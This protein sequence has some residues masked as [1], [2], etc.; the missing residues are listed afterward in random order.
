MSELRFASLYQVLSLL[1]V[2]VQ[3]FAIPFFIGVPE[4]GKAMLF[5]SIVFFAQSLLEPLFQSI[6]NKTD[7]GFY[8]LFDALKISFPF[9]VFVLASLLFLPF[10]F[11]IYDIYFI[12]LYAFFYLYITSICSFLFSTKAYRFLAFI[13]FSNLIVFVLSVLFTYSEMGYFSVIFSGFLSFLISSVLATTYL[14]KV[15]IFRFS[16]SHESTNSFRFLV[17]ASLFR[18]PSSFISSGFLIVL[19]FFSL[20]YS[21]IG[22]LRLVLST[23]NAGRYVNL[24]PVAV[25]QKKISDYYY[26]GFS[27]FSGKEFLYY[28]TS[29]VIYSFLAPVI[30]FIYMYLVGS[31]PYA[32]YFIVFVCSFY[33]LLQPI[34]YA[35]FCKVDSTSKAPYF[36]YLFLTV[37]LC[38]FS[39]T[40]TYFEIPPYIVLVFIIYISLFYVLML[41]LKGAKV[42]TNPPRHG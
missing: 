7:V 19:G 12:F 22:D 2:L 35:F 17:G 1:F 6:F 13:S 42:E 34:S 27:I 3:S 40:S 10:D 16:Y 25:I 38:I 31:E 26:R 24:V 14:I 15:S 41:V 21:L 9:L 5:L 28:L 29:I 37:V 11:R 20:P 8:F 36:N 32:G 4:Y 39:A 33:L 23:I 18:A 30:Y